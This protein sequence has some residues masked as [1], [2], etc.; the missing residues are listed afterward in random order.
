MATAPE[1]EFTLEI[2]QAQGARFAPH[3][4]DNWGRAHACSSDLVRPTAFRWSD[5]ESSALVI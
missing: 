3:Q 2:P 1:E 4:T 5:V